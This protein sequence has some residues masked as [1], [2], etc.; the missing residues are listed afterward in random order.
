[1]KPERSPPGEGEKKPRGLTEWAACVPSPKGCGQ[2][3]A[4]LASGFVVRRQ[5]CTAP[6][7]PGQGL[8][9]GAGL[10]SG[11]VEPGPGPQF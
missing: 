8:W 11:A 10:C 1:M 9:E 4:F 5:A 6:R 3:E 2:V 7:K